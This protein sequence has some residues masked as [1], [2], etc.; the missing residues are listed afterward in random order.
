MTDMAYQ[1]LSQPSNRMFVVVAGNIGSGKTT[2][3]KKS[4][5][6]Q[7]NTKKRMASN[8]SS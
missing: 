7:D 8:H 2:L 3:T 5:T 6:H 1:H 4:H